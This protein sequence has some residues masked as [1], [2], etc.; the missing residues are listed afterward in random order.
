MYLKE[1]KGKKFILRE[2]TLDEYVVKENCYNHCSFDK[3]DVWFDI[4]G[5]IGIFPILYG[6]KVKQVISFEPDQENCDL[7]KQNIEQN[8]VDNSVLIQK[9][10]IDSYDKQVSFF[11]NIKKNKGAHSL[12]VKKGRDEV[13]VDSININQVLDEFHP[14]KIKMDIEGGEY[15]LIK[16]IKDWSNIEEFIFEYHISILRD[17]DGEKLEELYD[18]LGNHFSTIEGKSSDKLG[19]NWITLVHCKK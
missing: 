3:N 19:K 12:F 2:E 11:L 15:S 18:I 9:A 17:S 4:G 1:I 14:N 6:S 13:I 5:N 10:V 16:A 8:N 7:F